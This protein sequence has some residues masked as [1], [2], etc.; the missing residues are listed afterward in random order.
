MLLC[1]WRGYSEEC[2]RVI[3]GVRAGNAVSPFALLSLPS[4][5]ED[6]LSC[7]RAALAD[8]FRSPPEPVVRRQYV[9]RNRI[10]VGYL[11]FDLRYHAVG[12]LTVGLFE[13]HDR[14][15]FETI[16][17]SLCPDDGSQV[18]KRLESA[19]DQFRDMS[20][21]SD[22]EIAKLIRGSE[23]DIVVDLNGF[24]QGAR[25]HVLACRPAPIQVNYLGYPG[26]MGADYIDYIIADR[27]VIPEDQQ[28]LY[29]EN[30]V[31][32]PH[33]YQA[34]DDRRPISDVVFSRGQVGLPDH[35]FVFCSFN[36]TFKINPP[37]FDIWM[38]LLRK[39]DGSVLWLLE[40]NA[41]A[42]DNLRSEAERRGVAANRLVFAPRMK[43]EDHIARQTLADL[44]LDTL[45][46]NAHTTASDALWV[47]LPV[48]TCLGPTFA[49]R[50]AASLLHAVGLP[51]LVTHSL[52]E[53]EAAALQLARSTQL[54]ASVK[55]KLMRNRQAFPLFDTAR[56]AR[57][58]EAAYTTM[59]ER[60]QRGRSAAGF[61]I[62]P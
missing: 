42:P 51:E 44:F 48:L 25:M 28:Q 61:D 39:I 20:L 9:S 35:G 37:V 34:N 56:F 22:D 38:R 27:I 4:S 6:Q 21:R 33:C 19:F 58:I 5:S 49:G 55:A 30:V 43:S 15:R 23:I 29:S 52:E 13:N 10:R 45:P 62:E 2:A 59:W 18:R 17:L 54:L 47:G 31:Y 3:S 26:T 40:G 8:E 32:L 53:Y 50:V 46:Y 12:F 24:T 16:A 14:S 41:N 60:Y 11:S 7:A 36:N 57:H 1:D